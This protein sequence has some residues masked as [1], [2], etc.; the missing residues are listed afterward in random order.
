MTDQLNSQLS[1]FVDDALTTEESELLVRRL[2]RDPQLRDT[3]A[4]YALIG[5]AV[6]GGDAAAAPAEFSRRVMMSIEGQPMPAPVALPVKSRRG[7]QFGLAVAASVVVAAVAL[8]TLPGRAPTPDA[9][10]GQLAAADPVSAPQTPAF[11]VGVPVARPSV[12]P[13]R[14]QPADSNARLNSYLVQH[15]SATG[16]GRGAMA[17]RNVGYETETGPRR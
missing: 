8:M 3:M 7:K 12:L 13:A 4:R 1:A 16:A 14:L 11:V 17:Y 2:C 6:R 5:N 10:P 9:V 15:A